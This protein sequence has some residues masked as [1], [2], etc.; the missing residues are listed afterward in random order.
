MKATRKI[1]RDV[2]KTEY[3]KIK[4]QKLKKEKA[5]NSN[6]D[7]TLMAKDPHRIC[8]KQLIILQKERL[9]NASLQQNIAISIDLSWTSN[10]K[11]KDQGKLANQLGRIYGA[12][13]KAEKVAKL[14]FHS[15]NNES[16]FHREVTNKLYTTLTLKFFEVNLLKQK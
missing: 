4:K 11:T 1:E 15:I 9:K 10:M 12:N 5:K 14:Y 6:A 13:K 2:R 8:K 3:Q 7:E 16:D